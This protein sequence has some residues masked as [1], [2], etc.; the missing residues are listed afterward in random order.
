MTLESIHPGIRPA[1][2]SVKRVVVV[3]MSAVPWA[4]PGDRWV[5]GGHAATDDSGQMFRLVLLEMAPEVPYAL[6][7]L[8]IP[9]L[10]TLDRGLDLGITGGGR[11]GSGGCVRG[12][13]L[14][15]LGALGTR[16]FRGRIYCPKCPALGGAS[17]RRNVPKDA[18]NRS[19]ILCLGR[20]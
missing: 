7:H 8:E 18:R 12:T 6:R 4:Q 16:S 20:N 14:V 1:A 10:L 2:A 5:G 9:A 13:R 11:R 19:V 3:P 17:G 15:A